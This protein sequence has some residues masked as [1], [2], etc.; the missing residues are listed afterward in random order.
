MA[1]NAILKVS[2]LQLKMNTGTDE[3]GNP[4]I[5]SKTLSSI[6]TEA[7]DENI[8]DVGF[9]LAG[10]QQHQVESIRRLNELQLEE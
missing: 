4:I 5:R 1:V 7:T 8:Y 2:K 3:K 10:L 9:A 6:D